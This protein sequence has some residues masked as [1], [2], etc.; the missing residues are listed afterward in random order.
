MYTL[1]VRVL[2]RVCVRVCVCAN[3]RTSSQHKKRE[4]T[5]ARRGQREEAQRNL[6]L[7]LVGVFVSPARLH[8]LGSS[9][10]SCESL[11][12]RPL[13]WC[14]PGLPRSSLPGTELLLRPCRSYQGPWRN[15][16]FPP[17]TGPI[18]LLCQG[19]Y[20]TFPSLNWGWQPVL[21]RLD[22]ALL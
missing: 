11:V 13:L 6:A 4:P 5:C 12:P 1:H 16:I 19:P 20:Y 2:V 9:S 10:R 14:A 21:V 7:F 18:D 8:G 15:T 3:V 22:M 17:Q